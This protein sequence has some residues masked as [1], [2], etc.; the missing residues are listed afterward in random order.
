MI[1]ASVHVSLQLLEVTDFEGGEKVSACS[2]KKGCCAVLV[3]SI[4]IILSNVGMNFKLMRRFNSISLCVLKLIFN[5]FPSTVNARL[6]YLL[7]YANM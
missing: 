5:V 4:Y 7:K 2:G 1:S 3:I 6:K